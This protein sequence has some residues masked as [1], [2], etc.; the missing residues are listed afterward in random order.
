MTNEQLSTAHLASSPIAAS[1]RRRVHL[2]RRQGLAN[3]L[4]SELGEDGSQRADTRRERVTVV[5][6]NVV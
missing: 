3:R 1:R 2:R 6:D 5:L 4:R